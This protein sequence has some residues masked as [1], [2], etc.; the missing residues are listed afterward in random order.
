MNTITAHNSIYLKYTNLDRI[1]VA[2][3]GV[4]LAINHL[5]V[6]SV[7]KSDIIVGSKHIGCVPKPSEPPNQTALFV[8]TASQYNGCLVR[9]LTGFLNTTCH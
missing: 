2:K 8:I 3:E 9:Q 5:M 4:N 7:A 6:D 1:V